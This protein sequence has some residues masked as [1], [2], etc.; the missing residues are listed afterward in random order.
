MREKKIE[1]QLVKE[2]KDIGGIALKIVSPGFDGMPDRLI[3]L[4]NRK[5]AFV[6]VKAPGKTLRPLQEK[7]KRQLEALGFLVFCLDHIDQI[8]GILHEIQ[9]S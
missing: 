6:E 2:V 1:Q 7:R 9:A 4:P 8:G 3:L 5:L